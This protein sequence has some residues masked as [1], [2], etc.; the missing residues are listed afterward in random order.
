MEKIAVLL[1]VH[2]E[3]KT[4]KSVLN[5]IPGKINGY[6]VEIVVVDDGSTDKSARIAM[7]HTR[8]VL[9]LPKNF[10]AGYATKTGFQY[11]RSL[12]AAQME[13]FVF[14][15][16]LDA[17]RQHDPGFIPEVVDQLE[18]GNDLVICSRF[19]PLSKQINVPETRLYLNQYFAGKVS[20][21][22]EWEITDARSGFVGM[23]IAHILKMANR[24]I[25]VGYGYPME[26]ILRLWKYGK[27]RKR[28]GL[29]DVRVLEIPHPAIYEDGLEVDMNAESQR[30]LVNEMALNAVLIDFNFTDLELV[31]ILDGFRPSASF[32]KS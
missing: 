29:E 31:H 15:V 11:I 12:V 10:G 28:K 8:Y 30:I 2:N 26:I 32:L 9:P 21:I 18:K 16:K 23:P 25:T 7:G 17:D 14:L 22:T 24:F 4:L 27:E 20:S 3:A 6:P 1:P 19:H 5:E 13:N